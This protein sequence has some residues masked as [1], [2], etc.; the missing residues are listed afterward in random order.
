MK[1]KQCQ[2][3]S[4]ENRARATFRTTSLYDSPGSA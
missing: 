3:S 2:D 1:D 4:I